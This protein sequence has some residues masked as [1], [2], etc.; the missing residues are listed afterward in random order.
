MKF[1]ISV[2]GQRVCRLF[3]RAFVSWL[4]GVHAESIR[5]VSLR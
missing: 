5:Y 3:I 1:S 2:S 4:V